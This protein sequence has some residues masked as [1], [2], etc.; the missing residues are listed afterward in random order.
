MFD[1]LKKKVVIITGGSGFFGSQLVEEYLK[2]D[3]KVINIDI[4][5]GK[6]KHKN[7]YFYKCNIT[8]EKNLKY[9]SNKIKKKYKVIDILINNAAIDHPPVKKKLGNNFEY[10]NLRLLQ[11]EISVGLVGAILCSK[12]FGTIMSKQKTG[13]VIVNISSDLGIIAPDQRLY[14]NSKFI[15]P[16]SYSVIKHGIIGLTKYTAAYWAK[17]NIRCNAF[18]PGGIDNKQNQTFKRKIKKLIPLG[19]MASKN[20][21]NNT[22]LFLSSNKSSYITGATI[23]ADGGRSII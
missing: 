21:Y 13:G 6:I 7:L 15:K 10:L 5:N 23:I 2:N 18:A 11:K 3:A 14:S 9:C 12:I 20:E 1:D 22:V 4:K 17:K 16:V 8:S 19:R